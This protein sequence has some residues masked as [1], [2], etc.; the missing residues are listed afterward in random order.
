[1]PEG[2][3]KDFNPLRKK[4]IIAIRDIPKVYKANF[5]VHGLSSTQLSNTNTPIG[6]LSRI[7]PIEKRNDFIM[8]AI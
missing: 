4:T 2:C 7:V 6:K 1:M 3:V 8:Q 5:S